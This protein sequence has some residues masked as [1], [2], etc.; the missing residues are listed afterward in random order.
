MHAHIYICTGRCACERERQKDLRQSSHKCD[1][2]RNSVVKIQT[3]GRVRD[4]VPSQT[5]PRV[6]GF[7]F[8]GLGFR[9]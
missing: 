3:W 9:V 4:S 2:A 7:G 8:G 1:S 5:D 6:Q